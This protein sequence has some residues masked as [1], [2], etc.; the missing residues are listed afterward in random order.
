MTRATV[1]M[2]S[3]L[4]FFF[5]SKPFVHF[6]LA[7]IVGQAQALM[8]VIQSLYLSSRSQ[9]F[10][11][12]TYMCVAGH[13]YIRMGVCTHVCEGKVG[14]FLSYIPPYCSFET[15]SLTDPE[16][17]DWLGRELQGYT[18]LS[19]TEIIGICHSTQLFAWVLEIL[20]QVFTLYNKHSITEPS[21]QSPLRHFNLV[22]VHF[23]SSVFLIQC[24]YIRAT[25]L[26]LML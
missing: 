20:T 17:Q 11:A 9:P 24:S 4:H 21:L 19:R 2:V 15:R 23:I 1:T 10:L 22:K 14:V 18:R 8:Y 7:N 3:L 25:L 13:V 6:L 12:C 26:R 5:C 16:I